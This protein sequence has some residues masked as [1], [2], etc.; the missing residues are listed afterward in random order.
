MSTL[1]LQL[2]GGKWRGR[3]TTLRMMR[4]FDTREMKFNGVKITLCK[5][6]SDSRTIAGIA[7]K[8]EE[9]ERII[10][11]LT[12]Y[13]KVSERCEKGEDWGVER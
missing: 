4:L 1:E 7:R 5:S 13:L 9:I 3:P 12:D 10:G 8:R 11:F 6:I 2:E